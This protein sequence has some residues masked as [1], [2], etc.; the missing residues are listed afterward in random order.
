M[1]K[2]YKYAETK[3]GRQNTNQ[4]LFEATLNYFVSEIMAKLDIDDVN[5]IAA[6]LSRAFQA[7]G[8]LQLSLDRNF[9]KVYRSDGDKINMDWKISPLA[10]YL[11]VINCNPTL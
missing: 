6:S 11:I 2:Q 3:L 7:C 8:T 9:K 5:E 1:L 4:W 10:C